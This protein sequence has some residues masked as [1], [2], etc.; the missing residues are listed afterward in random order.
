MI[1]WVNPK[2]FQQNFEFE[3]YIK[4]GVLDASEYIRENFGYK[5][6][7]LLGYCIGGT[8]AA[9]S[10]AYCAKN[11]ANMF[12]SATFLNTMLDFDDPGE[13]AIFI[14]NDIIKQLQKIST[15]KGYLDGLYLYNIFNLL[16][17]K[18]LIWSAYI[19]S[20]IHI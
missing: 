6:I 7:N 18:E 11:S 15:T 17:S 14:R 19:L 9:I 12:N 16:K 8:I 5:K 1:S 13:I 4:L 3:E 20:L 2:S 10:V